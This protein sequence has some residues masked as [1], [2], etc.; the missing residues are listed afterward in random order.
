MIKT[1]HR[2]CLLACGR[3]ASI[4]AD[5]LQYTKHGFLQTYLVITNFLPTKVR[6][7]KAMVFPVVMYGCESWAVKMSAYMSLCIFV[8]P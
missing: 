3:R 2:S 8:N 5:L 6:L 7:V 4:H 1:I